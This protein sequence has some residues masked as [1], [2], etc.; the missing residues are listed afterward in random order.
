[1]LRLLLRLLERADADRTSEALLGDVMEELSCGR[2]RL[3][4]WQQL[5]ALGGVTVVHGLQ[6][7]A[8][9][10]TVL[11][12]A[13]GVSLVSALSV[14]PATEILVSWA[15]FYFMSGVLSLVF[16]LVSTSTDDW[17]VPGSEHRGG[18]R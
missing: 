2:S 13:P 11:V 5:L 12:M 16:D 18:D 7:T 6:R 14:G 9:R 8:V 3:W 15:A 4:A 17:K 1:M 10:P